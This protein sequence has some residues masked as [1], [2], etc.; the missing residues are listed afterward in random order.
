MMISDFV[1]R[2]NNQAPNV[3]E[4]DDHKLP[5]LGAKP[6]R[7]GFEFSKNWM[8]SFTNYILNSADMCNENGLSE[9]QNRELG[10]LRDNYIKYGELNG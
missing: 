3:V 8:Q 7:P 6:V 9:G 4:L 5:I 1:S 10:K 2:S